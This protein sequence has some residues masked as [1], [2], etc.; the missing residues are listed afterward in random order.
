LVRGIK[1]ATSKLQPKDDH[2]IMVDQWYVLLKKIAQNSKLNMITEGW[3]TS[4]TW[5]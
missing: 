2:R 3:A 5:Y 4:G 1:K